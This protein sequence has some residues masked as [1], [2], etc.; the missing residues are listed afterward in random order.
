[1][2]VDSLLE[3]LESTSDPYLRVTAAP[4]AAW[5]SPAASAADNSAA[6]VEDFG[7]AE[8]VNSSAHS[9]VALA[10]AGLAIAPGWGLPAS[11]AMEVSR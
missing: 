3:N 9:A 5:K 11:T 1:M 7:I 4:A 6:A 2:F 10:A 8:A